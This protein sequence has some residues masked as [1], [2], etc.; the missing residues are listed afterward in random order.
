MS[1]SPYAPAG[2]ILNQIFQTRKGLKAIAYNKNGELTCSKTTYAQCSHVLQHK[3][4]LDSLIKIV[5]VQAKNEGLL[6]ILMYELLLG[7]N[8]KIRGG[9]ALK[10]QL[11]SQKDELISTLKQLQPE[12]TALDHSKP[13]VTIPRYVRINTLLS[14]TS[15]IL[16]QLD[17]KI[18]HYIDPHVPDVIV[19]PPTASSR[20]SLQDFVTSHK[21]VLQDKSSCFS[22]LCL[23]HG[24]ETKLKGDVLDACAAPGNKTSHVAALLAS[25]KSNVHALDMSE[26]RFQLLQ[27]R[28]R[29]LT[30]NLK[31]GM[32]K[33]Q[34][35]NTDFLTTSPQIKSFS[36][37]SAIM[38]D[39]SCSG[40]G[41]VSNHQESIDRD[42]K[43]TNDRIKSVSNF[44]FQALQHAT[45]NFP[46]VRR[47]VYSTCSVYAEENENVVQRLLESTD[48]WELVAPKCL[49][50]WKRRGIDHGGGFLA[51]EQIECLIRVNPEEDGSNGFFVACFQRKVKQPSR[52][53]ASYEEPVLPEGMEFYDNQFDAS[54][55]EGTTEKEEEAKDTDSSNKTRK[56][57][58]ESSKISKK[59]AKK[60]EW[61]KQQ[62][63]KKLDNQ[64]DTSKKEGTT[65]KKED[66]KDTDSSNKAD[67]SSKISK[68]QAKKMEWKKQQR[69]KKLD[70]LE[71]QPKSTKEE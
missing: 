18:P 34:C 59:R 23:V 15:D 26:D 25:S 56:Q 14:S 33:V 27:R 19:L 60:M 69:Q 22:A 2:H 31:T 12:S 9:G 64:F 11:V 63:Q 47:V 10:R 55:N 58:D 67:E 8:K 54:K 70:R 57:A 17:P 35:H 46:K 37:V 40:S 65:E 51:K 44:Q 21:V 42:P 52:D 28:M 36:K 16:P 43:F 41:M 29:E 6:Y 3:R 50:N 4:L 39:P 24:F 53:K 62:H 20:E 1:S 5:G 71:K 13:C 48:E 7:P 30:P 45:S 66:A 49:R 68:K 32:S 38:L 61:K